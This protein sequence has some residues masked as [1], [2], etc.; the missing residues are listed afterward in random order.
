MKLSAVD[1]SPPP[2]GELNGSTGVRV[3]HID[4]PQIAALA[5]DLRQFI[6][7]RGVASLAY[8]PRWLGVLQRS[9]GHVPWLLQARSDEQIVGI[10]PLGLVRSRLFGRYLVGLPYLNTGGV[11]AADDRAAQA[12]LE[13][14]IQLA[15]ELDVRHLELR[16]ETAVEHELLSDGRTSKVHMRLPLPDSS[17]RLWSQLKPKVRNQ[18]RKGEKFDFD[19]CWGREE[20]LADFY[21]V[22]SRNMRDLGTPVYGRRLFREILAAFTE[23]A[24]FCVL[25]LQGRP[26][27]AALLLHGEA[28]TEVPSASSLRGFNSSNANMLMYWHLLCRAIARH[29]LIFDFGRSSIDSGTYRFKRQWGAQPEGAAWQHYVRRGRANQMRPDSG[30]YDRLIRIWRRLPLPLTRLIGPQIVKGIP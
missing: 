20:L 9:L 24:E 13:R 21:D 10:L 6:R 15:G 8:D 2:D 19:V 23:E 16:H 25:R 12:L 14:A 17:D 4:V 27:A 11:L 26:V 18:V 22:F 7:S 1:S 3:S 29:S 5:E 30:K 28:V